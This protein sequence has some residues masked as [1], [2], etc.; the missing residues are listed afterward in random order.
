VGRFEIGKRGAV[1][2]ALFAV[3]V[4]AGK[5]PELAKKLQDFRAEQAK[6][7]LEEKLS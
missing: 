1:N 2:A 6:K 3:S 5:R 7:I 4:L